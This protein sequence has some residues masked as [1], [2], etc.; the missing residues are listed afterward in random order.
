M[1]VSHEQQTVVV[2]DVPTRLHVDVAG[3]GPFKIGGNNT[4][5][6]CIREICGSHKICQGAAPDPPILVNGYPSNRLTWNIPFTLVNGR[7]NETPFRTALGTVGLLKGKRSRDTA[8][9]QTTVRGITCGHKAT[10][11]RHRD[12]HCL[13]VYR[14]GN[15]IL[16]HGSTLVL[17]GHRNRA[18]LNHRITCTR[19]NRNHL[20][21]PGGCA[22][23]RALIHGRSLDRVGLDR[24]ID[25]RIIDQR[26]LAVHKRVNLDAGSAAAFPPQHS[27]GIQT[28]FVDKDLKIGAAGSTIAW[29]NANLLPKKITEVGTDRRAES[30]I[31]VHTQLVG[32]ARQVQQGDVLGGDT[33]G[34][35]APARDAGQRL[36]LAVR[37]VPFIIR[38]EITC[39]GRRVL[40]LV[41]RFDNLRVVAPTLKRI[42]VRLVEVLLLGVRVNVLTV[43]L[44]LCSGQDR[45]MDIAH[46]LARRNLR[47]VNEETGLALQRCIRQR[48]AIDKGVLLDREVQVQQLRLP[49]GVRVFHLQGV[50]RSGSQ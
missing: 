9:R 19:I 27:E 1:N 3:V 30:V 43:D 32:P 36:I 42:D 33:V 11:L 49:V 22:I 7:H 48:G 23:Q 31:R 5:A 8:R 14:Q 40:V 26:L 46:A 21:A 18:I 45:A 12:V 38:L 17:D 16:L 20:G 24:A 6:W 2:P 39:P 44:L 35:V 10:I 25:I 34:R 15:R 29:I 37:A 50:I 47:R 13:A 4:A 28:R 41:H